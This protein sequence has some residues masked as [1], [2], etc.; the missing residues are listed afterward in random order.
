MNC[1]I[2]LIL[3]L[4]LTAGCGSKTS[5]PV[6]TNDEPVTVAD[7][8]VSDD[9]PLGTI[10]LAD[11]TSIQ[12]AIAAFL[13][14]DKSAVHITG[15]ARQDLSESTWPEVQC[16]VEGVLDSPASF[17]DL[18]VKEVAPGRY[19]YEC[20]CPIHGDRFVDCC[21]ITASVG[22]DGKVQIDH[23][24]W[25]AV[26]ESLSEQIGKARWYDTEY[27]F[28]MPD[29]FS[30]STEIWV[31]D[32]PGSLY[33]WNYEEVCVA[34]WPLLGTWAVTDYPDK[35]CFLTEDVKIKDVTYSSDGHVFSG[36]TTDGRVWYMKKKLTE[37]GEVVHAKILVLIYPKSMQGEVKRLIGVVK[38]W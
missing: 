4:V 19:K 17:K 29:I 28:R 37:G 18:V 32:T 31:D 8:I 23:V 13:K 9:A 36:N 25:D 24:T 3:G 14:G 11:N 22:S 38:G 6:A 20:V 10:D 35:D 16:S 27:G 2:I 34:Y 15:T 1:K 26:T 7:S 12:D 30:P 21:T 5:K 33:R